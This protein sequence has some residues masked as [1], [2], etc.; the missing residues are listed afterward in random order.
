MGLVSGVA[1][2]DDIDDF[3]CDAGKPARRSTVGAK[4]HRVCIL[5]QPRFRPRRRSLATTC[6][7][8]YTLG[9]MCIYRSVY[10]RGCGVKMASSQIRREKYVRATEKLGAEPES[11]TG[12][13]NLP[14][15]KIQPK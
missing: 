8:P 12:G 5:K 14:S 11:L 10:T 6:E 15:D 13:V 4:I 1:K 3:K 9:V 7:L 2:Q